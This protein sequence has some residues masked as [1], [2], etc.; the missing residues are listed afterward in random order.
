M[1]S[2]TKKLN[3]QETDIAQLAEIDDLF[4]IYIYIFVKELLQL[5]KK[6]FEKNYNDIRENSSFL[7]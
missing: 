5:L 2:Y 1:L 3:V 7:K 6:D 4:E